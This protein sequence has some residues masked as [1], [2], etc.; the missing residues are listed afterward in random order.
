MQMYIQM[1]Q[2]VYLSV[3]WT[4]FLWSQLVILSVSANLLQI[5]AIISVLKVSTYIITSITAR[6]SDSK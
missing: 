5:K 4:F 1:Y 3:I 6:L 2:G